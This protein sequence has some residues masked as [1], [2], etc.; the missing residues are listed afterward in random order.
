MTTN[1]ASASETWVDLVRRT[2]DEVGIKQVQLFSD[3]IFVIEDDSKAGL[4]RLLVFARNLINGGI[5]LSL[6]IRGAITQG[7]V[8]WGDVTYGKAVVDA[9][10]LEQSSKWIGV[11]CSPALPR[12]ESFWSWDL[13][14]PYPVPMKS[15]RVIISAAVVWDI[16]PAKLLLEKVTGGGDV[17][18][19]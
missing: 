13:V 1:R 17:Q 12:V 4:E 14:V 3:T 10:K 19:G 6:P 11:T 9:H 18:R 16:P 15:G 5:S 2:S 8:A 7:S